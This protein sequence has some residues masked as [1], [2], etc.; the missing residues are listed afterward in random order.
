V[1]CVGWTWPIICLQFESVDYF[2]GPV[3]QVD[4]ALSFE[5]FY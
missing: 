4:I 2:Y 5:L 3:Y 1:V